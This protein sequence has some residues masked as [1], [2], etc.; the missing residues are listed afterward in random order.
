MLYIRKDKQMLQTIYLE[1]VSRWY[2]GIA[3]ICVYLNYLSKMKVPTAMLLDQD[4]NE[5]KKDPEIISIQNA[6]LTLTD[7]WKIG[8]VKPYFTVK[9]ELSKDN[10]VILRGEPILFPKSLHQQ[11]IKS[12]T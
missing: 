6:L 12:C 4:M 9:N 1:N 7:K 2:S 11:A 10:D 8:L 3:D 5:S